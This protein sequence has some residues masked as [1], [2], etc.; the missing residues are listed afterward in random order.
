M[1]TTGL[2]QLGLSVRPSAANFVLVDVGDGEAFRR[3]LL[4]HGIVV[5]DCASFGLPEYVRIACRPIAD[6]ERL[7]SVVARR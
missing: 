3:A 4:P 6:C 5:R 2:G 7:L 1:L